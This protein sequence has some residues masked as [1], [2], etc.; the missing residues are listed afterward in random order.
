MYVCK[1]NYIY[2][3]H[4]N[5]EFIVQE[6]PVECVLSLQNDYPVSTLLLY[7]MLTNLVCITG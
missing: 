1:H 5:G 3:C 4:Y 6:T 7:F 2:V